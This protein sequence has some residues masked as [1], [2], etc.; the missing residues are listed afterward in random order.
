MMIAVEKAQ[1]RVGFLLPQHVREVRIQHM[2][3][4]EAHCVWSSHAAD[5]LYHLRHTCLWHSFVK[6]C[7]IEKALFAFKFLAE[8]AEHAAAI[9]A[10]QTEII[11]IDED[12][13]QHVQLTFD[14]GNELLD[15]RVRCVCIMLCCGACV[16][17]KVSG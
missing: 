12:I 9:A 6:A 11:D 16:L 3:V 13:I 4:E 17:E 10:I 14:L 15:L 8:V 1:H 5:L 7:E 2:D